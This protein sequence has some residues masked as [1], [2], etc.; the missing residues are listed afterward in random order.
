MN[1]EESIEYLFMAMPSFQNVGG[2]VYKP[3]LERIEA[4][5]EAL[6]NPQS[7]YRVIHVAGTNG[8][9]ST[10]HM[11]ASVM[12]SAGYRVGLFTSPHLHD[13]RERM[14]VD[15]EMISENEV[16]G[17]VAQNREVMEQ[18]RLSFFEMTAAMAFDYFA[19]SKVDVA[20]V[21]T[22]LGGRL[23]ATNI[24]MPEVSVITNIG[25]DHMQYLGST[26]EAIAAEKAGIIKS[27]R[28]VVVGERDD[29]YN[30]VFEAKA[31]EMDSPII[32]AED[33][34]RFLSS[35]VMD[36]MQSIEIHDLERGVCVAYLLRLMGEYQRHNLIT[37]LATRDVINDSTDLKISTDAV[38]KGLST[39]KLTATLRGRWQRLATDPLIVCDTGHNSHGL[40]EVARQLSHQR[41]QK[42]YCVLGFAKDK[43]VEEIL[44]FFPTDA[45]FILT[46]ASIDRALEIEN[47]ETIARR[48]KLDFETADSVVE[49]L[50]RAKK[51]ATSEDM[52]YIG[53]STFVVAELEL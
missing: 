49:A 8:K 36:D 12:E 52:I 19:R 40:R 51:I 34:Y 43:A 17:F 50:S 9:G 20:V 33:R 27:R 48:M 3:G 22:G 14:R 41:Y 47:I 4:F 44:S 5:C 42:L 30:H 35:Q 37:M 21:E 26:L 32:F 31:T 6:G 7:S 28:S 29:E 46:R 15:G 45:H 10:S 18:L 25:L 16:V 11:L 53:G 23:D 39:P 24:V 38:I 13:F 2:D 1:Y